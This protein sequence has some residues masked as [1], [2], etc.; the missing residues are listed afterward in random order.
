MVKILYL[1]IGTHKTGSTAIQ[2]YLANNF[3][4]LEKNNL[5]CPKIGYV[6]NYPYGNH[7][8]AWQISGDPRL[9]F[10]NYNNN[11]EDFYKFLEK[12]NK[13]LVISS[14]DFQ[15]FNI[16][17]NSYEEFC[18]KVKKFDY[19][20]KVILYLRNQL[21]FFRGIYQILLMLG[22]MFVNY[23]QAFEIIQQSQNKLELKENKLTIF[24]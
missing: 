1:H 4:L 14:E 13:N 3:T 9:K 24:F 12:S 6:K 7:G 22:V 5:T 19:K 16:K 11:L 10:E 2:Q 20:I 23:N 21:D 8:I 18:I 17:E 15:F